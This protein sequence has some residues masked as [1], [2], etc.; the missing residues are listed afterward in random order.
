M[1]N[2]RERESS[3]C[4][5]TRREA[6]EWGG[7]GVGGVRSGEQIQE[8]RMEREQREARGRTSKRCESK[9]LPGRKRRRRVSVTLE[10]KTRKKRTVLFFWCCIDERRRQ[11]QRG[12]L[13]K[14]KNQKEKQKKDPKKKQ[15]SS[16]MRLVFFSF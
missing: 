9:A 2:E 1:R 4:D 16:G 6:R 8:T 12:V 14:E 11:L 10:K 3:E 13:S 7:V 15:F 5:S